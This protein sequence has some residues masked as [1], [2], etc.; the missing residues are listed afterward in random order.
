MGHRLTDS[1]CLIHSYFVSGSLAQYSS[2]LL[3]DTGPRVSPTSCN[4]KWI[5][6]YYTVSELK[7]NYTENIFCLVIEIFVHLVKKRFRRTLGSSHLL[8]FLVL[9]GPAFLIHCSFQKSD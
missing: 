7:F 1:Y 8:I 4:Q 3:G 5:S 2:V 6:V 9:A